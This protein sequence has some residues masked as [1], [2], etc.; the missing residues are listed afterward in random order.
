[1]TTSFF[2]GR[3]VQLAAALFVGL[4]GAAAAQSTPCPTNA[5]GLNGPLQCSCPPGAGSGSVWGTGIYTA[6]SNICRAAQHAGVVGTGGGQILVTPGGRMESYSGSTQYGITTSDWG[7]YDNSFTVASVSMGVPQC[8]TMPMGVETYTCACPPGPH[9]GSAWGS[10]PYTNDS[11]LCLAATHSGVIGAGGGTVTVIAAPG[12][13]SYRGSQW[14][15]VTTSD[16]GPWS[17][18]ITFNRN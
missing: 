18:S 15:G 5:L 14:N 13:Q 2:S 4:A 10:G 1:M 17:G 6:D 11:N 12:L 3:A 7:A 8:G 9:G 16:Y